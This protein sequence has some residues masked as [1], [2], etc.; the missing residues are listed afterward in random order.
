MATKYFLLTRFKIIYW[1]LWWS[2]NC[3]K[4]CPFFNCKIFLDIFKLKGMFEP[5][6]T[7]AKWWVEMKVLNSKTE[8]IDD[9]RQ[10]DGFQF[11]SVD[12]SRYGGGGGGHDGST[13]CSGTGTGVVRLR[14]TLSRHYAFS[15]HTPSNSLPSEIKHLLPLHCRNSFTCISS[16]IG[17]CRWATKRQ[18]SSLKVIS[19][20]RRGLLDDWTPA[21]PTVP[22]RLSPR[23]NRQL[24]NQQLCF[25]N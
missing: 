13:E 9:Y 16:W 22:Y 10:R 11:Y 14:P 21:L 3:T 12:E 15:L 24:K 7:H 25:L 8:I 6:W 20:D 5:K 2:Q 18:Q 1:W 19:L 23:R 17:Q 4:G